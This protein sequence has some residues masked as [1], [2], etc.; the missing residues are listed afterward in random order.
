MKLT[1]KISST[2]LVIAAFASL[3]V[4][5]GRPQNPPPP[6]N[7]QG[8]QN[9]GAPPAAPPNPMA[10]MMRMMGGGAMTPEMMQAMAQMMAQ[11]T[12]QHP[13]R[14]G[15]TQVFSVTRRNGPSNPLEVFG[16]VLAA[17][18]NQNVRTALKLTD[19]QADSLRKIVVDTEKFSITTG[20]TMA[21]D[22]LD[23]RE[24]M[25]ADKPERK[26]VMARGDEISKLTGQLISHYLDAMLAA[27]A[28][29]TPEQQKL[30]RTYAESRAAG[31]PPLPPMPPLPVPAHP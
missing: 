1:Y 5:Q 4:A 12:V 13:A 28:I 6:P 9:Q 27:K 11:G 2:A 17:L 30:I 16:R 31:R 7:E 23:L 25:R 3:T 14:P 22:A 18:D 20:A 21:V 29:L 19:Q 15:G 26:D 10:N 8:Q 24:Q